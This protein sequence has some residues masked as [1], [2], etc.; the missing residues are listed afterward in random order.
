MTNS[1]TIAALATASGQGG[2]AV[3]RVSGPLAPTIAESIC[4]QLPK[5]RVATFSQFQDNN[6]S[7]ID[8]GLVLYFPA[9]HSFTGEDVIE[10]QGH[11]GMVVQ[12]SLLKSIVSYGAR[13][14]R[15]GEFSERAFLNGKIDLTQA[16][17]IADLI[18]ASSEQ[19]AKSAVRSLTGEFAKRV[20][21]LS[22]L[23]IQLRMYVEAAIDFPD[24]EDV[25]FLSDGHIQSQLGAIQESLQALLASAKQGA[26]L[27]DGIQVVIA[28]LPNAGKSSLLNVLSGQELAI[29]TDIP[30]TT[31][32]VLREHIHIDGMPLHVI[33]TAGLRNTDDLVEQ[34]GVKRA[35]R[36]IEAADCLILVEDCTAVD[37][38][39]ALETIYQRINQEQARQIP[40]IVVRN[41]VD[42][43]PEAP[44]PDPDTLY[45]S[46]K[47]HV[48]I[49]ALKARLKT[50][51]GYTDYQEGNIIAR[52]RHIEAL[53]QAQQHFKEAMVQL[54]DFKA[55]ELVAEE[56]RIAHHAL[57]EITGE[58]TSDDLLGEI[59][60]SFCIGK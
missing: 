30:G 44:T 13:M 16:E 57:G 51:M 54:Q 33:D 36:E 23:L 53:L 39:E 2:V 20:N 47:Q 32:D 25:D 31:R 40:M 26:L 15:P 6:Q 50:L 22:A 24:E 14:A 42:L 52:R 49:D 48:G 55:G 46:A 34:E 27:R 29:V 7:L 17:A 10:F 9:P 18:S 35:W 38:N 21:A 45:I 19:A 8:E 11:G 41:K 3:V 28:G 5:P 59:F 56:L 58:F 4:G 37:Q 43:L 12:D 60:S 1:D